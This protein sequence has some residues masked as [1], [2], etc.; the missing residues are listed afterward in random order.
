MSEMG[1]IA[2]AM[3][4]GTLCQGC[5]EFI[6]AEVAGYCGGC[7]RQRKAKRHRRG[8]RGKGKAKA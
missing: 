5:G 4:D 8:K 2:E 1:E 3:L 6:G 7:K